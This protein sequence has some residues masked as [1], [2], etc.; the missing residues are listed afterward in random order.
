MICKLVLMLG[1]VLVLGFTQ[2]GIDVWCDFK[3]LLST[4]TASVK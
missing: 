2:N 3:Y 4:V 1:D